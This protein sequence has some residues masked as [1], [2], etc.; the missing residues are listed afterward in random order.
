MFVLVLC[1]VLSVLSVG[2]LPGCCSCVEMQRF[3]LGLF[4]MT[5]KD[6]KRRL[7]RRKLQGA[8]SFDILTG[9]MLH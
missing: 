4:I 7:T 5:S 1:R 9:R 8:V 6:P 3:A 2:V